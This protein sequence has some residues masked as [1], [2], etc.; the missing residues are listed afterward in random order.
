MNY[1]WI[2]IPV[3]IAIHLTGVRRMRPVT[4]LLQAVIFAITMKNILGWCDPTAAENVL[5]SWY[6]GALIGY[7][8]GWIAGWWQEG[9]PTPTDS[10]STNQGA[11]T[12]QPDSTCLV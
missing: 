6:A 10:G 3:L 1:L 11:R 12:H 8:V 7:Q 5:Q 4:P 9:V 2:V